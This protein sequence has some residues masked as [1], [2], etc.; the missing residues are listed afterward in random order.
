M[1]SQL[2]I[3]KNTNVAFIDVGEA[4]PNARI[5]VISVS[6]MLGLRS[7]VL[8]R[9]DTDNDIVLGL[10]I[11]EYSSFKREIMRKYVAFRVGRIVDLI[12]STVMASAPKRHAERR[13]LAA[14]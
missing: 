2:T 3:D 5:E 14:V 10:I 6:D 13:Q 8:A 1:T 9:I 4:A 11:E 7:Q 12:L